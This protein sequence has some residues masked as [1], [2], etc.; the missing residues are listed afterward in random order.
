[1]GHSQARQL[2]VA[3]ILAG[4]NQFGNHV[5]LQICDCAA[6]NS[7]LLWVMRV[8]FAMSWLRPLCSQQLP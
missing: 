4:C 5:L 6:S 2:G 8:G 7:G 1:M 3:L